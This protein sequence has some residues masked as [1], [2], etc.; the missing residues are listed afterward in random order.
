MRNCSRVSPVTRCPLVVVVVVRVPDPA[1]RLGRWQGA[2]ERQPAH[3]ADQAQQF[4]PAMAGG[5]SRWKG[6]GHGGEGAR[7]E[8]THPR[9]RAADPSKLQR[10]RNR[11]D[12]VGYVLG[13]AIIAGIPIVI[14]AVAVLDAV[15]RD[16]LI[17][18]VSF[19]DELVGYI[20]RMPTV[21]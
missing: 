11:F 21:I 12:A 1:Q 4:R 2:V 7:G 16:G 14:V 3:S 6:C 10:L 5:L 15:A 19:W 13:L 18:R 8:E 20:D 9:P 17:E